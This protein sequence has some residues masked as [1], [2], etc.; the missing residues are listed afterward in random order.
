MTLSFDRD[1][2]SSGFKPEG[3]TLVDGWPVVERLTVEGSYLVSG[4]TVFIT[5]Y[6]Q[7]LTKIKATGGPGSSADKSYLTMA[8]GAVTGKSGEEVVPVDETAPLK[9]AEYTADTAGPGMYDFR[10][11]N[12]DGYLSQ[13]DY[14]AFTFTEPMDSLGV[15]ADPQ[16]F[17]TVRVSN[18]V[19]SVVRIMRTDTGE[20]VAEVKTWYRQYNTGD[21]DIVFNN[22][23]AAWS[24]SERKT[25]TITLCSQSGLGNN[26]SALKAGSVDIVLSP[27]F[28]DWAGNQA[29]STVF[30]CKTDQ[31]F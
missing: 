22:C 23:P 24:G 7:T 11:G 3:F 20:E 28:R 27:F 10:L 15:G 16:P 31:R 19:S 9:A 26:A 18:D 5:L 14:M 13:G 21:G 2:S 6:P 25:L 1:V 17:F 30:K 12:G 4:K 29:G 8:A